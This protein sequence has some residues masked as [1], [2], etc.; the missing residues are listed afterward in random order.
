MRFWAWKSENFVY[1]ARE[2]PT[3]DAVAATYRATRTL[4][5]H[6]RFFE[7]FIAPIPEAY[8]YLMEVTTTYSAVSPY[9][10]AE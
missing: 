2:I 10:N 5:L 6:E 1:L 7:A 4:A 3:K 8:P 9:L